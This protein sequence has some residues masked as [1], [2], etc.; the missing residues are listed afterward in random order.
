M[1]T[2]TLTALY[3]MRAEADRAATRLVSEAGVARSD[4]GVIAHETGSAASSGSADTGFLESLKSLFVPDDDRAG[5]SEAIRRG[6]LLLTAQVEQ[7]SADRAMGILEEH[8]AVD[9]DDLQQAWR[10]E[11]WSGE[12]A[13]S[14]AQTL[15]DGTVITT[16]PAAPRATAAAM[17]VADGTRE[18]SASRV[19]TTGGEEQLRVGKRLAQNGRVRVRSY[20]VETPVEEQVTLRDEH[21]SV[22]RRKVDRAPT[23]ADDVLFWGAH[24]RS[25]GIRRG[26]RRVHN[27]ACHR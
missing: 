15:P 14:A 7:A 18:A 21:V 24:H 19:D 25:D 6:G 1:N 27:R 17:P 9:L 22:E 13:P 20:V 11:G 4:V 10:A 8:G 3:D 5:Y 26:G 16:G 2:M 12:H 23:A